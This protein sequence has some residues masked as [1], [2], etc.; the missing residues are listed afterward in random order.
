MNPDEIAKKEP[1]MRKLL[2]LCKKHDVDRWSEGWSLEQ[3]TP[4]LQKFLAQ[5]ALDRLPAAGDR[6]A[7]GDLTLEVVE[8]DGTRIARLAVSCRK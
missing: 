3:A 8:M 5:A 7:W 2:A 4:I 1:Y 6:V